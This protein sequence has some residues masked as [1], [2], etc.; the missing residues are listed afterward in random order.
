MLSL[1]DVSSHGSKSYDRSS[2]LFL[3]LGDCVFAGVMCTFHVHI[4]QEIIILVREVFNE[5]DANNASIADQYVES[6][7]FLDSA[8]NGLSNFTFLADVCRQQM[9][10]LLSDRPPVRK[11]PV[12]LLHQGRRGIGSLPLRQ[13]GNAVALPIPEAA[14]VKITTLSL[15]FIAHLDTLNSIFLSESVSSPARLATTVS[16]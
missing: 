6:V 16:A 5:T 11:S 9:G 12:A 4:N 14:P 1:T 10:T 3:E 8:M 7:L 15:S 2:S 13:I